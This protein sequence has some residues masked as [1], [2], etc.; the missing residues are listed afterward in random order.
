MHAF[1]ILNLYPCVMDAQSVTD[2]R[3]ATITLLMNE[4]HVTDSDRW[5]RARVRVNEA[6]AALHFDLN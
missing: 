5:D 2:A 4:R 1:G 3:D 6:A